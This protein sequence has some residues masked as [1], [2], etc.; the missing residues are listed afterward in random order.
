MCKKGHFNTCIQVPPTWSGETEGKEGPVC[1]LIHPD[2]LRPTATQ[3]DRR[4]SRL[5]VLDACGEEKKERAV[6][7]VSTSM[8]WTCYPSSPVKCLQTW[9]SRRVCLATEVKRREAGQLSSGIILG[10]GSGGEDQGE[11]QRPLLREAARVGH[12]IVLALCHQCQNVLWC[13]L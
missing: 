3:K 2:Q 1:S 7:T 8:L 9:L 11:M 13:T 4:G 5:T 10:V 12:F 6:P